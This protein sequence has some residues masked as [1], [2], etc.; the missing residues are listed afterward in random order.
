MY[1]RPAALIASMI[2]NAHGGKAK[3][4]DFLPFGRELEEEQEID[5]DGFINLLKATGAKIGR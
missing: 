4:Q 5:G 2:N 1:D 3:P